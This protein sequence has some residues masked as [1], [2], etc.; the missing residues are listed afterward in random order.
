MPQCMGV[1]HLFTVM[2][3]REHL[4]LY[5]TCS[6]IESPREEEVVVMEEVVVVVMEEEVVEVE[7]QQEA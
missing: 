1:S 7:V 2:R 6:W 3:L 5:M 4:P